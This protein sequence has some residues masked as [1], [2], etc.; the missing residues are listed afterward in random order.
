MGALFKFDTP[1]FAIVWMRRDEGVVESV[2]YVG[3]V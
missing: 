2:K 3:L 1:S